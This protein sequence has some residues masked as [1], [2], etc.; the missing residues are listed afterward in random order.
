MAIVWKT[1][2]GEKLYVTPSGWPLTKE[3]RLLAD[4]FDQEL[5]KEID[6]TRAKLKKQGYFKLKPGLEKYYLLGKE[7]QRINNLGLLSK[8]DPDR[9]NLWRALYDYAPDFAPQKLPTSEERAVGKRNFF[10]IAYRLGKVSTKT[11]KKIQTWGNWHDIYMSFVGHSK[12]WEDWERLLKWILV[13][14]VIKGKVDR[15]KLRKTLKIMR[16]V[17]GKRA[18]PPRD[19]TVLTTHELYELLNSQLRYP[20]S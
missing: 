18:K 2:K 12:L 4:K 10:L 14:S 15:T 7:L 8:C 19:T 6:L 9:E 5:R 1:S 17:I 20:D 11:L 3:A 13:K 16:K